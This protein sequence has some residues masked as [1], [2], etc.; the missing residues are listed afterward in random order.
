MRRLAVGCG[1]TL[2]AV[3]A[4]LLFGI[5]AV[6]GALL[7]S[8]PNGVSSAAGSVAAGR[9]CA[10]PLETQGY[11]PG[12]GAFEPNHTGIDF[13]CLGDLTIVAVLPGTV[14]VADDG[15][16]SNTFASG[17]R[18]F[19][20]NVVVETTLD[21]RELFLRYGHLAQGSLDVPTGEH[22]Q[23]GAALGTEGASGFATGAHVHFEVDLRAPS[24]ADCINPVPYLDPAIVHCPCHI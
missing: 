24:T 9:P 20:C 22:V 7:P 12:P 19:G 2:V 16:C 10:H 13:V 23:A 15:P 5:V 17:L 14:V 18:V 6:I 1:L 8:L 3:V 11:K 21:G 4:L